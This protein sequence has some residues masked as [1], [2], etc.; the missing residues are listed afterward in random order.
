MLKCLYKLDFFGQ[1]NNYMKHR[2]YIKE[3]CDTLNY[4]TVLQ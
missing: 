1:F 2:N 3:K 4:Q